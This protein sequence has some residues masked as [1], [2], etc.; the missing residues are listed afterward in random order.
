MA[1]TESLACGTPVVISENCHFPEVATHR[2]GEVTKLDSMRVGEALIR[3]L[4]SESE[5]IAM[6]RRGR[7]LVVSQFVWPAIAER[8]LTVYRSIVDSQTGRGSVPL[9]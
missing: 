3:V 4:S 6:G 9:R 2:A 1:I 5:R 7:E 8:M